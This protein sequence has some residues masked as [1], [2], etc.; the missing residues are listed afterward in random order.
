[1]TDAIYGVGCTKA[2][3]SPEVRR[4]GWAGCAPVWAGASVVVA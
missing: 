3:P 2:G 4:V 1:M